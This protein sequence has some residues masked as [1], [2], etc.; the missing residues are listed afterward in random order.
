M[1]SNPRIFLVEV[2]SFGFVFGWCVAVISVARA[3][4]IS[5]GCQ[6]QLSQLDSMS[7]REVWHRGQGYCSG[8][9]WCDMED[10]PG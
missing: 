7:A 9:E 1:A 3:V 6:P 5:S 2:A 4:A 8:D 10:R